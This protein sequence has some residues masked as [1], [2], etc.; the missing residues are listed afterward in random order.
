[1]HIH[2]YIYYLNDCKLL[3]V[4]C[5]VK[6]VEAVVKILFIIGKDHINARDL[7]CQCLITH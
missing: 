7:M 2:A 1:M 6:I 4:M 5:I 3:Y